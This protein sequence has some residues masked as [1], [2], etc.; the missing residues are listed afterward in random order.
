MNQLQVEE[1]EG[2]EEEEDLDVESKSVGFQIDNELISIVE[3]TTQ[4]ITGLVLIV[5]GVHGSTLIDTGA[6]RSIMDVDFAKELGIGVI[7]GKGVF[8]LA[9]N[10]L[11]APRIGTTELLPFTAFFTIPIPGEPKT[12]V[13]QHKFELS[14]LHSKYKYIIGMDLL[15]ILFN[16]DKSIADYV[17]CNGKNKVQRINLN[18]ICINDDYNYI[19]IDTN[20]VNVMDALSE[21][22]LPYVADEELLAVKPTMETDSTY[23]EEYKRKR[24]ELE[25][26]IQELLVINSKIEGYCT[27]PAAEVVLVVDPTKNLYQKQYKLAMSVQPLVTSIVERWLSEGKIE[28]APNN[29]PYN[30][31]LLVVPKKNAEGVIVGAR[32]CLDTRKVNDA[33]LME[34]KFPLP[35]IHDILQTFGGKKSM[36]SLI[37]QKHI[38][39]LELKKNQESILHLP[40][41]VVNINL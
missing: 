27:L 32:V 24:K 37:Y 39:N 4:G 14:K 17:D 8:T 10:D 13:H 26:S 11:T 36:E 16:R 29:C 5:N 7:K 9:V 1:E 20:N 31:P 40:G 6:E 22:A 25:L 30:N 18:K 38:Y 28:Q 15:W 41:S 21:T 12:K 33:L 35:Y 34:D 2:E 23:E 19:A 3:Q